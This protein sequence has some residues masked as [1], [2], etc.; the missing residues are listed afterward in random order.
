MSSFSSVIYCAPFKQYIHHILSGGN[1]SGRKT[2]IFNETRLNN[3][4]VK[5]FRLR[6]MDKYQAMINYVIIC[7]IL[8]LQYPSQ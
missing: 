3:Y 8:E 7:T 6:Y 2:V 4:L 1:F 5:R